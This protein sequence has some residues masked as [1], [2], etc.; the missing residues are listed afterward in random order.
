[1]TQLD[2]SRLPVGR[3]ALVRSAVWSVPVVATA[4]AA[5]AFAASCGSLTAG[6]LDWGANYTRS[7]TTSGV[8]SV[9][10]SGGEA[11]RV[12]MS[13]QLTNYTADTENY[14]ATSDQVG[15][16][17][18][19]GFSMYQTVKGQQYLNN[20]NNCQIVTISF[21][22]KVYGLTFTMTD[23]DSATGDFVDAIAVT[24]DGSWSVAKG[25]SVTGSGTSTS[26]PL[27]PTGTNTRVDN[28][29]GAAGNA[30]F[31][32]S[33]AVSTINIRYWSAMSTAIGQGIDPDQAVY[34]GPFTFSAYLTSG[35]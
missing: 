30:K 1:M 19:Q 20:P 28:E 10:I 6:Y 22:R 13:S 21:S 11:V 16:T 23:I 3:R 12:T 32:F 7:T 18:K 4:A 17:G 24:S 34:L 27:R 26:D 33:G 9:P 14:A 29:T 5:P 35:C 15:A 31:T 2:R 8:A 25:S